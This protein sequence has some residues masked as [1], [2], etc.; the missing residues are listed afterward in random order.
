MVAAVAL[1]TVAAVT[2]PDGQT[3][4][5]SASSGFSVPADG[6]Q[7]ATI[8]TRPATTATTPL[9]PST[10][11]PDLDGSSSR[12][13]S[14]VPEPDLDPPA[15]LQTS[16]DGPVWR[17]F[18]VEEFDGPAIDTD[19]WYLYDSPGNAG[20]GLRRPSAIAIEDGLLVITA[21]MIDGTLVSG[22]MAHTDDQIY[23][24]WTFRV[25]TEPDPS[26]ATSGVVLTWPESND[27]PIDGENDMYE[28]GRAANRTP[29]H[30][31]IHYGADNRQEHLI[32]EADGTQWQE[33]TMEW[34]AERI[35]MFRN[36]EFAGEIRNLEA[37]PDVPHHMTIQLDAWTEVMS[38]PVRMYVDWVE[39]Y[40]LDPAA[41]SC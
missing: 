15:C 41:T 22:G 20:F 32:H 25:L 26:E 12:E 35:T 7:V 5:T 9:D 21:Q 37:I 33:I 30:T 36:G 6:E 31:F 34:T 13:A 2:G 18:F 1:G 10:S 3:T 19:D 8:P 24:R 17:L 27:W 14:A 23:G 28:T 11:A 39:V 16:P 38:D 4:T 29:F 40:S